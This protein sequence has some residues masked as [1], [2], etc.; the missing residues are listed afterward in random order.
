MRVD[1]KS[2]NF[3]LAVLLAA[4]T[5]V[6]LIVC[7]PK[8][9]LIWFAP[10][11]LAPLLVA[12][13]WE[14]P[15]LRNFLT[16]WIAGLIYWGGSCYWIHFVLAVHGGMAG[17]AAWLGFAVFCIYKAL[18]L[19]AFA[20]LAGFLI[21][22]RWAVL[23]IPALWVAI[24]ST[25]GY[26][27]FAWLDLGNAGI[28]MSVLARLAPWTGV[29]GLSFAFGMMGTA[30]ALLVLRRPRMELVPLL[31]LPLIALAPP[32]PKAEPGAE[33][34]VLVQPDIPEEA[35]WTAQWVAGMQSRLET[36]TLRELLAAPSAA[37]RLIVWP[38]MPMPLYYDQDPRFRAE[39]NELAR[40]AGA[41]LIL[42]VTPHDE[43]GAPRNSALLVS[44]Q[45]EPVARYDKV[46][47]VP[48]GEYVPGFFK[49]LVEKVSNEAGDFAP[50]ERQVL[51]PA[52]G[53]KIGAFICY[54]SVF[55]D[56]VR[57]FAANGAEVLVN[58]SNDGWYG[59]TAARDQHLSI[60]RMRA[61]ENRRWI[62]RATNDGITS[63]IDPA[64]RV[65]RNLPSYQPG[66][67]RTGYTWI[68]ATTFYSRHGNW[69]VWVCVAIAIAGLLR[70]L[71]ASARFPTRG[72]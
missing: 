33:S 59:K 34:A 41:W 28:T 58:I 15:R 67:A 43:H 39:V 25:H 11:A 36:L 48:F 70:V 30:V 1:P 64:G 24:E 55:P 5:A 12:L 31:A 47:L 71:S 3:T 63:T 60:V 4:L 56:Y 66:A 21:R 49:A 23:T 69:F 62:L 72:V 9:N 35:D 52:G 10:F 18:P 53:H 13:A 16:G 38:E 50:G 27:G 32:L 51:L 7:F 42:N 22:R 20:L 2:G 45:G 40:R 57:R 37:P 14:G 54:E 6:L 29:Y 8:F 17:W 68:G 46:N 61:A 26:F 44:P 19:G 65:Y